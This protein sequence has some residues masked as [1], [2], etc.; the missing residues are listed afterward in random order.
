MVSCCSR[1]WATRGGCIPCTTHQQVERCLLWSPCFGHHAG[2]CQAPHYCCTC[3]SRHPSTLTGYL[4][5]NASTW[6][7]ARRQYPCYALQTAFC[8]I[9]PL[10]QTR[11]APCPYFADM[12]CSEQLCRHRTSD[13]ACQAL[14]EQECSSC[15]SR[16]FHSLLQLQHKCC[17]YICQVHSHVGAWANPLGVLGPPHTLCRSPC[18]DTATLTFQD[19]LC[20]KAL[21]EQC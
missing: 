17:R 6:R 7:T 15:L 16:G 11:N 10:P 1:P 18:P 13:P 8:N 9:L 4:C 20:D 19:C 12:I 2:C 14:K 5:C 3:T 21:E